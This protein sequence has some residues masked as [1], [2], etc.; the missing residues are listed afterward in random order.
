MTPDVDFRVSSQFAQSAL[1]HPMSMAVFDLVQVNLYALVPHK[2]LR[3]V[4]VH[5]PVDFASCSIDVTIS[6]HYIKC[7]VGQREQSC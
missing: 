7:A 5:L 6:A 4:P 1:L 2:Y 3:T